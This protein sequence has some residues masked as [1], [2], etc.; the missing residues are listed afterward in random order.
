M[1]A[2][3]FHFQLACQTARQ[4]ALAGAQTGQHHRLQLARAQP[5]QQTLQLAPSANEVLRVARHHA[6]Q[7]AAAPGTGAHSAPSAWRRTTTPDACRHTAPAATTTDH[8]AP[9][10]PCA[11]PGVPS[12]AHGPPSSVPTRRYRRRRSPLASPLRPEWTPSSQSPAARP[13]PAAPAP[14][15]QRRTLRGPAPPGRH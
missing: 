12:P 13:R 14:A 7:T 8:P 11:P 15:P 3:C 5:R 9:R 4:R 6:R 1:T 10:A 2:R